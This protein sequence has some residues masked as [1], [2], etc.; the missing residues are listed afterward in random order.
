MKIRL[1]T[2]ILTIT[3]ISCST[4]DYNDANTSTSLI[5]NENPP[6]IEFTETTFDFGSIN[7]G[8][9]I[10]H[11]FKFKNTGGSSLVIQ[12]VQ[13][14]CGCTTPSWPKEA[15][16]PGDEGKI[17]VQFDSEWKKGD[18]KKAI[19]IVDN[20][21]ETTRIYIT[22]FIVAPDNTSTK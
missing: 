6:I 3:A 8:D 5:D 2:F 20:T 1:I 13:A 17:E 11:N 7:Q 4:T 22:G 14:D 19:T 18:I 9:I 12:S 15:I 21:K 16:Q 10:R